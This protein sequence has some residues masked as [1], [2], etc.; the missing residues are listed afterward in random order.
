MSKLLLVL[1]GILFLG[2]CAS[3]QSDK[4]NDSGPRMTHLS[5]SDY[6]NALVYPD[7]VYSL[8]YVSQHQYDDPIWGIQLRYAHIFSQAD[9]LDVYVYPI[10]ATKWEEQLTVLNEETNAVLKEITLAVE[11]GHYQSVTSG[12]SG[13]VNIAGQKGVKT[14]LELTMKDGTPYQSFVYLF[15]Q[16]DKFIKLRFSLLK[17]NGAGLPNEDS[18][19]EE[20]IANIKVPP[21]SEYMIAKREEHKKLQT[22]QFLQLLM[23]AVQNNKT[24]IGAEV[25]SE[26][27]GEENE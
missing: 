14:P 15:I 25:E 17:G 11:K 12:Q 7:K 20:I 6:A 23:Q 24:K 13:E 10:P 21:E 22:Q 27:G 19:A 4:K 26:S 16:Q 8:Q 1:T 5:S 3:N 9:I 18:L 2:A